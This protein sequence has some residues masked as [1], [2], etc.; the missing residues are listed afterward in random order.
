M[1][2]CVLCISLQLVKI[3][4]SDAAE[5]K[6]LSLKDCFCGVFF[7]SLRKETIRHV[8]LRFHEIQYFWDDDFCSVS[9]RLVNG[10][11]RKPSCVAQF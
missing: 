9:K 11:Y 7:F 1:G 2:I 4:L 3:L 6:L 5:R 10:I 8:G